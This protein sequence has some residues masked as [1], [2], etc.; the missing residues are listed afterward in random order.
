MSRLLVFNFKDFPPNSLSTTEREAEKQN[1]DNSLNVSVHF[2]TVFS[3]FLPP[4]WSPRDTG[5]HVGGL[6]CV[7]GG[8]QTRQ[9]K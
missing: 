7:V 1:T 6:L 9:D 8:G 4:K 2:I 5:E 3:A